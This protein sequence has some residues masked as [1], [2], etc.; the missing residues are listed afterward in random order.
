M[1][2]DGT[3]AVQVDVTNVGTR[4]GDEVVQLY[5]QH[6][7]SKVDRSKQDL[8]GYT[9][10]SLKP[11][12]TRTVSLPLAAK[13]LAYWDSTSH[14]WIVEPEPVRVMIGSSSANIRLQK[15]ISVIK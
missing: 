7:G 5:V 14:Q 8:R 13:S 10:V 15:T 12:E 6:A 4:A 3:I 1:R 11:G 2:P 9:R